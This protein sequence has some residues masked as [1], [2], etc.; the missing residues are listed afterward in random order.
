M[1]V[2]LPTATFVA[3]RSFVS[4]TISISAVV[5]TVLWAMRIARAENLVFAPLPL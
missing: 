3:L 2:S 1:L 5:F 4:L